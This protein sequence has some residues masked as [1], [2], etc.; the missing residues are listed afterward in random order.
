M[1]DR[2]DKRIEELFAARRRADREQT[3]S[4]AALW[5]RVVDAEQPQRRAP[6]WLS[7]LPLAAAASLVLLVTV[8]LWMMDSAPDELD[9]LLATAALDEWVAPSS[10]FLDLE[11]ADLLAIAEGELLVADDEYDDW[12]L[13]S[14]TLISQ[15]EEMFAEELD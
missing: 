5:S 9:G 8:S 15:A 2:Y 10:V 6:W 12:S 3:P 14:D 4:F 1:S 13:P 7:P 11:A